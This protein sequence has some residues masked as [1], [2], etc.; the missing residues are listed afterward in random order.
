MREIFLNIWLH[1]VCL[2]IF[3]DLEDFLSNYHF[4]LKSTLIFHVFYYLHLTKIQLWKVL[5]S[6]Q[7]S[8]LVLVHC[9]CHYIFFYNSLKHLK[10]HLYFGEYCFVLRPNHL[11]CY[12]MLS[13]YSIHQQFDHLLV[14][15]FQQ[16]LFVLVNFSNESTLWHLGFL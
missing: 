3:K 13:S 7:T 8:G 5:N 11:F 10:V 9:L 4:Y 14:W 1:L 15:M 2:E 16:C 12:R 6:S